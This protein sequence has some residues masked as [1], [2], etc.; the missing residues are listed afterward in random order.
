[1]QERIASLIERAAKVQYGF[2]DIERAAREVMDDASIADK[3]AMAH[4]LYLSEIH[5]ARVL[6]VFMFGRL[7]VGVPS[8]LAFLRETVSRDPD[9]RVQEILAKAFDGFCADRGYE[10][11]L[12]VIR[13]WLSDPHPNVRRA[14]SEGLRI[15]TARPYFKQHPAEAIALLAPHHADESE[16]LRK[17]IGNALRDISRTYPDLVRAEISTWDQTDR[18]TRLTVKLASKFLE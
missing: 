17:S 15:W 6:A 2:T 8:M 9:W 12:P 18:R 14:V 11:S 1:M 10:E 16:Y 13:D 7:A 4:C 3:S 5:Q